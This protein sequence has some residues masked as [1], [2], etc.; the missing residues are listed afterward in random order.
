[1]TTEQVGGSILAWLVSDGF[2]KKEA[3]EVK[4]E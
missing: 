4:A 2:S 1:M 3:F